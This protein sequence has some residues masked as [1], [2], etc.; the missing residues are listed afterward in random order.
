M[1][2]RVCAVLPVY[3]NADSVETVVKD[4][5]RAT[6]FPVLVVDDGSDIPILRLLNDPDVK[7]NLDSGRLRVIRHERNVGKGA[8]LQTAF[9][10]CLARGYTHALTLDADGQH[11]VSEVSKL[12]DECKA[13]PWALIVGKRK[14][15]GATVPQVSKFGRSFSNFWVKYQ[16]GQ[17]IEDSQSGLR[18]YPLFQI[19][20]FKFWTKKFDFEIEVLIRLLWRGNPIREVDVDCYYPPPE[21]RVTHFDKLWDNVRISLLNTALVVISLLRSH[22]S[23]KETGLAVGIGALIG[24]TPFIGFHTLIVAA[25]A[26]AARLNGAYLWLGTQVSIPPLAPLLAF[27]SIGTGAKLLGR[28]LA[29]PS[30]FTL[31]VAA[32][33]FGLWLLGSLVVGSAIGIVVGG[34][35]FFIA[36]RYRNF[37][38]KNGAW[39]GKTRGGMLGHNL[40]LGIMKLLGLRVASTILLFVVPYFYLFAPKGR[41][42]SREYWTCQMPERN[43]LVREF[44]IFRHF[45]R[46]ATLLLDRLYQSYHE[47]PVFQTTSNG[48]ENILGPLKRGEGLILL[49]AHVGAW[50]MAGAYV[51]RHGFTGEFYL[52]QYEAPGLTFNKVKD[53]QGFK[54]GNAIPLYVNQLP[55]PMIA[56]HALLN[57]GK[58]V[59]MMGDRPLGNYFELVPFMG[60][61]APFDTTAFRMAATSRKPLLFTFG[62]KGA[63]WRYDFFA[64][65]LRNYEYTAGGDKQID[66]LRWAGEY[67]HFLEGLLKR[68][69][70][71]WNNFFPFWSS[72][73]AAPTATERSTSETKF[74]KAKNYLWQELDKRTNPIPES[75]FGTTANGEREFPRKSRLAPETT[76]V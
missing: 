38:K 46:F 22:L 12:I 1:I 19:Q 44:A 66:C 26:F 42:A 47:K 13:D 62:F 41:R 16:T 59:A 9:A 24:T 6:S 69:P 34:A 31:T 25:V 17:V 60:K 20:N 27:A 11:L 14:M 28:P 40:L 37:K 73:P 54:A 4:C 49:G 65:P 39:S 51:K 72:I 50:D 36:R 32:E 3:N 76:P 43:F 23:P 2:L 29:L 75:A 53:K 71:Q 56:L 7:T 70:E 52:L 67:A 63:F 33:Y 55:Q 30:Q 35:A 57:Q 8:A 45:Y 18:I 48:F 21:E 15:S 58:P 64:S 10:D 61:L 74:A 5:L 68:Y